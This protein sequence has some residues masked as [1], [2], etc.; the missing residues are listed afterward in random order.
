MDGALE[1]KKDSTHCALRSRMSEILFRG[2]GDPR[3]KG[4]IK[5]IYEGGRGWGTTQVLADIGAINLSQR[6]GSW[7]NPP[8]TPDLPPAPSRSRSLSVRSFP[9]PTC[10][11][12]AAAAVAW[13]VY[14]QSAADDGMTAAEGAVGAAGVSFDR[15]S[16]RGSRRPNERRRLSI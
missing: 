2:S 13:P 15:V 5:G 4:S 10:A 9:A 12:A 6:A 3:C 11:D 1:M 7:S 8:L 14:M 16:A